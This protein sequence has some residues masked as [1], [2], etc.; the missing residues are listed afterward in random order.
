MSDC[1]PLLCGYAPSLPPEVRAATE[2]QPAALRALCAKLEDGKM[3]FF[4]GDSLTLQVHNQLMCLCG[5]GSHSSTASHLINV[6]WMVS[7]ACDK[8]KGS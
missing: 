8:I 7:A 6:G 5:R 1:K 4:A 2:L 3:T